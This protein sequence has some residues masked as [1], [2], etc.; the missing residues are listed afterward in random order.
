[1]TMLPFGEVAPIQRRV[2]AY[3]LDAL[4]AAV[5]PVIGSI[6]AV[7]MLVGAATS[8]DP[9]AAALSVLILLTV[10]GLL[11]LAWFVVYTL[12]QAGTGSI[13]MRA[14]GLRLASAKDGRPIGFGRALLRNIVF[15]LAGAIVVG[16]FSPLFDGSGRFQGWHDKAADAVMLDARRAA[17][18]AY[19]APATSGFTS[20]P[21]PVPDGPRPP[22]PFGGP[23]VPP[24]F[25]RPPAPPLPAPVAAPAPTELPDETVIA[26]RR[27]DALPDDPLISFVP[28]V[29]QQPLAPSAPPAPVAAP[30]PVAPVAPVVATP[31][32]EPAPAAPSAPAA[33]APASV[34]TPPDDLDD[35]IESTRI[36]IPGHRLVFTWDD[37]Q[38]ASVSGRTVFGRNPDAEAG[39][40]IVAVRDETLSLSKTHFEAGAAPSGGWV[41]D[42][43]ST[44]GTVVV[45][46]GVRIACPPGQRV[47]V[48]LG[49][50]IEIGDRIVTIGGF[51]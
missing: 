38:R 14:Q 6:I 5:I 37:G 39:A 22:Q 33:A 13:G 20:P 36:S 28:G 51:A 29:T 25:P 40:A 8:A 44:N 23:A 42:R 19:A 12:M 48:R 24:G 2:V 16:Y 31:A 49:D 1:M 35:D 10:L 41:M 47:P 32:S 45:R 7:G 26:P 18:S 9:A 11:E 34:T 3:I 21:M 27:T 50:A 4:I 17:P 15:G 43:Q 30:A 46:D